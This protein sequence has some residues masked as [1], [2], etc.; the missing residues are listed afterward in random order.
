MIAG[1][2]RVVLIKYIRIAADVFTKRVLKGN[3]ATDRDSAPYRTSISMQIV[4][5]YN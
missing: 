1:I 3:T 2:F 5:E 4:G